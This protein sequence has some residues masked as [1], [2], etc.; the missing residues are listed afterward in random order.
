MALIGDGRASLGGW[1]RLHPSIGMIRGKLGQ[2][3]AILKAFRKCHRSI[4]PPMDSATCAKEQLL[5]KVLAICFSKNSQF[6]GD[7][8]FFDHVHCVLEKSET[9]S[10]VFVDLS[11]PRLLGQISGRAGNSTA[12][13]SSSES[14]ET[15]AHFGWD[16][17]NFGT[18]IYWVCS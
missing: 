15:E 3:P 18:Q 9:F 11:S 10:H 1:A 16:L 14:S 6:T 4:P 12:E 8:L 17:V 7:L 13:A 5:R 2:H